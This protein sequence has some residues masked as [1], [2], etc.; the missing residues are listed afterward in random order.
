M[1]VG[2]CIYRCLYMHTEANETPW[3]YSQECHQSPLR[4]GFSLAWSLP[5][6]LDW[7]NIKLQ[8]S[9]CLHTLWLGCQVCRP[10]WWQFYVGSGQSKSGLQRSLASYSKTTNTCAD[11]RWQQ[12][13]QGGRDEHFIWMIWKHL[14]GKV[15]FEHIME[16]RSTYRTEQVKTPG[17]GSRWTSYGESQSGSLS[18]CAGMKRVA[19]EDKVEREKLVEDR[20]DEELQ[21]LC[22][23]KGEGTFERSVD[24]VWSGSEWHLLEVQ[25]HNVSYATITP[26]IAWLGCAS[27]VK[28]CVVSFAKDPTVFEEVSFDRVGPNSLRWRHLQSSQTA[29]FFWRHFRIFP[30]RVSH[31][32]VSDSHQLTLHLET[33]CAFCVLGIN[34]VK[35]SFQ[36]FHLLQTQIYRIS[37]F[38][39]TGVICVSLS[40]LIIL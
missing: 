34:C 28:S 18:E 35:R 14:S 37:F 31:F 9:S 22:N 38:D 16:M 20:E 10:P 2:W 19:V 11:V 33:L 39:I 32:P 13:L 24:A 21:A 3:M 36:F 4:Q 6:G 1:Y 8:G 29:V 27:W 40:S 7:L 17:G 30:S 5:R 26:W 23:E 15:L 12:M 25:W